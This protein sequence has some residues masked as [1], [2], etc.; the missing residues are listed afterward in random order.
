MLIYL[1]NMK[2]KFLVPMLAVIGVMFFAADAQA[3]SVK[4]DAS[5][6]ISADETV[7]GN[8]Y[9]AGQSITVDGAVTGDVICAGQNV[10][11]NGDV[12]GDVICAAQS[13]SISGQVGG[14]VRAAGNTVNI[15]NGVARNVMAFG[16]AVNIGSG[17]VIGGDVLVAAAN[18][19]M[20]GA[21]EGELHG[22]LAYATIDGEVGKNINLRIDENSSDKSQ[23]GRLILG[24]NAVV[25]GG[26]YY[27]ARPDVKFENSGQVAGEIKRLDPDVK[28]QVKAS[29][30][31]VAGRVWTKIISLL[32]SL[33]VALALVALFGKRLD[34][35]T[36][37][38][39][40]RIWP[41]LGWGFAFL[42]LA[43]LLIII[44]LFTVIG[45][46]A[47]ALIG[48]IWALSVGLANIFTAIAL[49]GTLWRKFSKKPEPTRYTLAVIGVVFCYIIFAIPVLGGICAFLGLLWGLGGIWQGLR[50]FVADRG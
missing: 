48:L 50:V 27:Y 34:K 38:M 8:L 41:S 29:K 9:A 18:L 4:T 15:T 23:Q 45:A 24:K 14:N 46:K 19:E 1:I 26:I 33:L 28:K 44:T 6:Y 42:V 35:I 16:A 43:P 30:S 37:P 22:G 7:E 36:E 10:I 49:G 11:I 40:K 47:G 12:G 13:V 32:G 2:L 20:R 39:L 17:A 5:V 25:G 3:F 31:A 21:I